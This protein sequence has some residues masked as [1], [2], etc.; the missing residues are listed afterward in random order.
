MKPN[1][2]HHKRSIFADDLKSTEPTSQVNKNHA[3]LFSQRKNI[4]EPNK[5]Q[6]HFN[7]RTYIV[8]NMGQLNCIYYGKGFVYHFLHKYIMYVC[9]IYVCVYLRKNNLLTILSL[10]V[11]GLGSREGKSDA[12][13]QIDSFILSNLKNLK[14]YFTP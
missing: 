9:V 4:Q 2:G 7:R 12:F 14:K 13:P 6:C 1:Q 8:L 5:G 10:H 11:L 3:A